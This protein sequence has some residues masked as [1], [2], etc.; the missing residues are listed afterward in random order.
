M[1]SKVPPGHGL[2]Y[3]NENRGSVVYSLYEDSERHLWVGTESG[4]WRW[5]PGPPHRYA[6]QIFRAPQALVSGDRGTG[7]VAISG[8][9]DRILL[10]STGT[11]MEEYTIP[12]VPQL[13]GAESLLRDRQGALWIGTMQRGLLHVQAGES[14]GQR[15][16]VV[17]RAISSTLCWRIA[18]VLFGLALPMASTTFVKPP[19]LR[20]RRMKDC[21]RQWRV[22]LQPGMAVFGWVLTVA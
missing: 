11:G 8:A 9:D 20:S 6:S 10:Q 19:C 12:G 4:L 17:F 15:K 7:L 21:P 14:P 18:R 16:E 22:S 13:F 5:T 2:F 1:R 3:S